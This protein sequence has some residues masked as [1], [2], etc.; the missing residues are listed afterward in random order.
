M[1]FN[2]LIPFHYRFCPCRATAKYVGIIPRAP[3]RLPRAEGLLPLRGANGGQFLGLTK[4]KY[5]PPLFFYI[6]SKTD[7]LH[8]SF[9]RHWGRVRVGSFPLS[10]SCVQPS[11]QPSCFPCC[12]R[13]SPPCLSQHGCH[14]TNIKSREAIRNLLKVCSVNQFSSQWCSILLLGLFVL[15]HSHLPVFHPVTMPASLHRSRQASTSR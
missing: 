3:L 7:S 8:Q 15:S 5:P 14:P 4:R 11:C 2:I 10:I 12:P 9:N 6:K 13:H 1:T